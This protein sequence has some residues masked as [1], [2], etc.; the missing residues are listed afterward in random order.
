[1]ISLPQFIVGE[2]G[3]GLGGCLAHRAV[4]AGLE[5]LPLDFPHL[6]SAPH[7]GGPGRPSKG[8]WESLVGKLA[9][10]SCS[11]CRRLWGGGAWDL[12]ALGQE[13][14]GEENSGMYV[15]NPISPVV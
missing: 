2:P 13:K 1:M 7:L 15:H 3:D 14:G 10:L 4:S 9:P 6:L 11:C 8:L 12:G 5:S